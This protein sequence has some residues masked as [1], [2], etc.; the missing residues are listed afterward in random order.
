[1]ARSLSCSYLAAPDNLRRLR[2]L[3]GCL[4]LFC[5][6]S[7][8]AAPVGVA[9]GFVISSAPQADSKESPS[10]D[11]ES[12]SS[13]ELKVVKAFEKRR[14]SVIN[15]VIGSVVA[16]YDDDR[17]GGGSGVI[18]H[19]SGIA[20]TNHHVIMGAGIKGWGGLADGKLYRWKLIGTDPGG[21][22][23]I[24]QMEGRDDFP[25]T[26]LGDSDDV[27]VGDWALAM[28]NP[29]ILTEDQKP[30]VTL[31]IV[32][33]VKRYQPG[34][35]KNQ[36]V[37]GNC[38]QVDSSINPGNSGGP[39]FNFDGR[40]IGING[41]GSFKER[42]RVNVGLGYAISA[43]Q[44][45]N[46]IPDLLATKLVEHATLDAN[47]DDREGKVVCS[48]RN[49]DSPVAKA[50]LEL[51]DEL[52]EFE[53]VPIQNANQYTN[54]ICTLPEDWPIQMRIR[55][56]DGS[57]LEIHTRAIGLPYSRPPKPQG[58]PE[59]GTPEEQKKLQRQLDMVE[60]LSAKPGTVRYRE[61]NRAYSSWVWSDLAKSLT[62]G[63]QAEANGEVLHVQSRLLRND[64]DWGTLDVML[65][66]EGKFEL[67]RKT[68]GETFRYV[69]DGNR[70]FHQDP[71]ADQPE[72]M[73]LVEA[74]LNYSV[75]Y[76]LALL[77]AVQ[78]KPYI[79]LG[80]PMID[81]SGKALGQNAYRIQLT[82]TDGDPY[83]CWVRMYGASGLRSFQLLKSSADRDCKEGGLAFDQWENKDGVPLPVRSR[84]VAGLAESTV[85][86]IDM[87]QVE[88]KAGID[89]ARFAAPETS[90][91]PTSAANQAE[92]SDEARGASEGDSADQNRWPTAKLSTRNMVFAQKLDDGNEKQ[93]GPQPKVGDF[94]QTIISQN[95]SRLVKVF[96]AG[97]GKVEGF[98]TGI[99]VSKDG[100]ILT[101][102]GVYLDGRQV[103][104]VMADG[105]SHIATILKRDRQRQLAL[106][107]VQAETP[108]YYELS[109]DRVGRK[110]DW[111]VA[112]C[113]A[114][115]VAD[116]EEP[117]SATLG[118]IS[119]R[120]QIEARLSKRDVA[121]IGDLILIDAIT[122]NPGAAGGA[123]L[124]ADGKLVGMVGK[125]INSSETNTRLNYA[126][127]RDLL[128]EFLNGES[129]TQAPEATQASR[130]AELGIVLFKLG[131]RN[132]PAYIDRV[133][134]RSPAAE[135]GLKPDD[136]II[137]IDGGKIGN[138]KDYQTALGK[139]R[140]GEEVLMIFKRGRDVERVRITPREK[141]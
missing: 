51:G 111:V 16:I 141:K 6:T 107:K 93:D 80:D 1:M 41:R 79:E 103:T 43:N 25:F 8:F 45:K 29:F 115:R 67:M 47:F 14:V 75:A 96:G 32:S 36:L 20:L 26:P 134:R 5:T 15:Q 37:Y 95:Q 40:V 116:K 84:W 52:L 129:T 60:L 119:L 65:H 110:G 28:G 59:G 85:F 58:K 56:K 71:N 63:Q 86:E 112:I 99:L 72:E 98:S 11:E 64:D 62:W 30:T 120:T 123:V 90:E 127:P 66:Q 42:K 135:A 82:D 9:V 121:Y 92:D 7:L 77:S 35:G 133:L 3:M 69:F 68:E 139:L 18:I 105:T 55:K 10:S 83:F 114:F 44:I 48:Q 108:D 70:F 89:A 17:Q 57:E 130:N 39:L 137:S 19:P 126:V 33:G 122:S 38:I 140:P 100:K 118:V 73:S 22:V 91:T 81:G 101:S 76:G 97:V 78:Q 102:Q 53:G 50:G 46:F 106:L 49:I 23:S 24:I 74:K 31:G 109:K 136:M 138:M 21:D 104:V 94:V 131:G 88:W 87:K 124:A 34:A 2:C 128:F 54:L 4:L 113:N 27:R 117:I 61:I 125:I 12:L 132:S 13:D